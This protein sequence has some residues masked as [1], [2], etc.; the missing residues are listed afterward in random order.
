[1]NNLA[2]F[3]FRCSG[4]ILTVSS[5]FVITAWSTK[6]AV[7]GG[8]GFPTSATKFL[9]YLADLPPQARGTINLLRHLK[10]PEGRPNIYD[11]VLLSTN[12]T[13]SING[14]LILAYQDRS[15]SSKVALY[16]LQNHIFLDI[17]SEGAAKQ[18][19]SN[20]DFI[21]NS[22]KFVQSPHS[23]RHRVWHPMLTQDGKLI[24][25]IPWNDIVAIDL[26]E[27]REI[28][29]VKGAFHHS[30]EMDAEGNIWACAATLPNRRVDPTRG[31]E[32]SN[33]FFQDQTVVKI[34]PMG[35]VLKTVSVADALCRSGMEY[36]LYGLSNPNNI[37]DPIHLNQASPIL[38]EAE[39]TRKGRLL[40][41]LR[42]MSTVLILDPTQEKV[43]WMKSGPWMNQ[44]CVYACDE[45]T[46]SLLDNHSFASGEY[47]LD[48]SWET[49]IIKYNL[50]T[51]KADKIQL[52]KN[53]GPTLK[54]PIEG[55]AFEITKDTWM[56]EDCLHGTIM[57]FK[58]E[59]VLFKWSNVY[60]SGKVG[61]TSWCRYIN[62]DLL[63]EHLKSK[64]GLE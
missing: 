43:E 53:G 26:K 14:C 17:Y 4:F 63:P 28:W 25:V 42:N 46:I 57:I 41:S 44:H 23:S 19:N 60:P 37:L 9:L 58:N 8:K 55:R 64:M 32:H 18:V 34:S 62:S 13:K 40:L 12:S 20:S 27:S 7:N 3:V 48:N 56:L 45:S 5:F 49:S 15:G 50:T 59:S 21:Y 36:I 61:I 38:T 54:I 33:N 51:G 39:A 6:N 24:Y 10:P 29:R 22:D 16:N 2:K 52:K 11:E 47:W 1:M 35:K 30:V 31:V